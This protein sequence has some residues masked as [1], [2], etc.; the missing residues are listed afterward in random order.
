MEADPWKA[1]IFAFLFRRWTFLPNLM[2][3]PAYPPMVT[4]CLI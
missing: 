2:T 1:S 3:Y 4:I